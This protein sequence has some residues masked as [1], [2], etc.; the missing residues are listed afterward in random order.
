MKKF[1]FS[2]AAVVSCISGGC[3]M[4]GVAERIKGDGNV[5]A[6]ERAAT[7]FDGIKLEGSAKVRVHTGVEPRVTVR[8][9]SNLLAYVITDVV[10]GELVVSTKRNGSYGFTVLEVDVYTQNVTAVSIAGSG[11]VDFSDEV[12]AASFTVHVS[13]S[14][15]VNGAVQCSE[16]LDASIS[17]SGGI[18]LLISAKRA[19]ATITGSGDI[20]LAGETKDLQVH[21]TGS[22][23]FKGARLKSGSVVVSVTGSGDAKVWAT[24]ALD[25][26]ITGSSKVSYRGNPAAVETRMTGSG[27][28]VKEKEE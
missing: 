16:A 18:D 23:D 28:L 7:A 20:E 3:M 1:L 5:V 24:D 4:L 10:N 8:T 13:G 9:D 22:G 17:G 19:S 26:S 14:G 27:K 11:N 12:H 2:T 6:E 21:T 15:D 25:V